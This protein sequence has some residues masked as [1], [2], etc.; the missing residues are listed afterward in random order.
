M[1]KQMAKKNRK[2][3]QGTKEWADVNINCYSGCLNNCRYCY[4]KIMAIRFNRKTLETWSTMEPNLK[5]IKRAYRK[6]KGRVMFPTSHDITEESL[7]GCLTVLEQLFKTDNEVLVTTKPRLECVKIICEKFNKFKNQ[8]QFRFTITSMDEELLKFWEPGAPSFKE[9]FEALKYAFENG[10]KTSISI[11]PFLDE[12]VIPLI[13]EIALYTTESIWVGKM[14]YIK[15]T[16]ITR[17]E[18]P[19]YDAIRKINTKQKIIDLLKKLNKL[20]NS[21][22]R[23]KDS[24]E[25]F[26]SH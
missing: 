23:I 14:N 22:I 8:I 21:K 4:A 18:Q 26:I 7:D 10:Y 16:G 17:E 11:E 5:N 1:I 3:T 6:Q 20:N 9:R 2:I 24:I 25:N 15:A 12:N 13:N 19:F